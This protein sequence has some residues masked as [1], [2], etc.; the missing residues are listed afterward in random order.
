MNVTFFAHFLDLVICFNIRWGCRVGRRGVACRAWGPSRQGPRFTNRLT[1]PT[2]VP[3]QDRRLHPRAARMESPFSCRTSLRSR[4]EQR[5]RAKRAVV[6]SECKYHNNWERKLVSC[7]KP[8]L[9]LPKMVNKRGYGLQQRSRSCTFWHILRI[10]AGWCD[11]LVINLILVGMAVCVCMQISRSFKRNEDPERDSIMYPIKTKLMYIIHVLSLTQFSSDQS[12]GKWHI[13]S[14]SL[15]TVV[16]KA[17]YKP[18][19][20]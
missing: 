11:N 5:R 8:N 20:Q 16:S 7:H 4:S 19:P 2:N 3:S 6:A 10:S 9:T 18:V 14:M 12:Y 13:W 15:F 1:L 17:N